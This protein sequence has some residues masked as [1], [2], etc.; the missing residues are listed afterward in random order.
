M[1]GQ[2]R[3]AGRGAPITAIITPFANG[4]FFS[5]IEKTEGLPPSG[6]LRAIVDAN[7]THKRKLRDYYRDGPARV[8]VMTK[9]FV[10]SGKLSAS[11]RSLRDQL[12]M[13]IAEFGDVVA[14]HDWRW[15]IGLGETDDTVNEFVRAFRI[16]VASEDRRSKAY[17][18]LEGIVT[19]KEWQQEE[20]RNRDNQQNRTLSQALG[21]I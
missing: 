3:L 15:K 9:T 6:P 4:L 8:S 21:P 7:G 5:S 20:A 14:D 17:A 12:R 2:Q 10:D 11:Q 18:A 13:F 16:K 1:R 19:S